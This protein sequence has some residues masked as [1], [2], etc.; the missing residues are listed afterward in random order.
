MKLRG[1]APLLA[2]ALLGSGAHMTGAHLTGAR[3]TIAHHATARSGSQSH[4]IQRSVRAETRGGPA[5][6]TPAATPFSIS[7]GSTSPVLREVGSQRWRTTVLLTDAYRAC[8]GKAYYWL[9]TTPPTS[10]QHKPPGI[11]GR[12][13]PAA[14]SV[15]GSSCQVT[16]TFTGL[17]GVPAAATLVLDQGGV[18]SSIPLTVSRQVTSF[19]SMGIPAIIGG[20]LALLMLVIATLRVRIYRRD[21]SRLRFYDPGFWKRPLHA[22]SAWSLNDSWATNITAAFAVIAAVLTAIPATESVFPG[23]ALDRFVIANLIAGGIVTISPLVFSIFYAHWTR[24]NLGVTPDATLTLPDGIMATLDGA[25]GEL[26]KGTRVALPP[27]A[28]PRPLAE[29]TPVVLPRG[30]PALLH[31]TGTFTLNGS[32][33]AIVPVGAQATL[34]VNTTVRPRRRW[35]VRRGDRTESPVL[36][37][38]PEG[39]R[40]MVPRTTV[41]Q[42]SAEGSAM[43]P[44]AEEVTL[45]ARTA[46]RLPGGTVGAVARTTKVTLY[47][48]T[49]TTLLPPVLRGRRGNAQ[50]TTRGAWSVTL[51]E[52]ATASLAAAGPERAA[53]PAGA[54]TIT[55]LPGSTATLDANARVPAR[56]APFGHGAAATIA[57]AAGGS[58][59]V[60]VDTTVTWKEGVAPKKRQVKAG[61][62]I[63]VPPGSDI[64]V[65]PGAAMALPGSTVAV[66]VQAGSMLRIDGRPG[67]LAIPED[68]LLPP[69]TRGRPR[70]R[71]QVQPSD[72]QDVRYPVCVAA[73]GGAQI[74]VTGTAD[75]GLPRNTWITAPHR[76]SSTLSW[77]RDLQLPQNSDVIAANL[78]IA[79]IAAVVTMFGIGAEIGVA[80]VL[81]WHFSA[82]SQGW[83]WAMLGA[84]LAVAAFVL[85]YAVTAISAIADPQPGSSMSSTSGASFTL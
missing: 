48:G 8:L 66:T 30:T 29:S 25:A 10:P 84:S 13:G 39:A 23:V 81:A 62:T 21:G 59:T 76:P 14:T 67:A 64:G 11:T 55:A 41:V 18:L 15:K 60:P 61:K 50:V 26:P 85:T 47:P 53:G 35:T 75:V 73:S 57:V 52:G 19:W 31:G 58:I 72:V 46:V 77:D 27:A 44:S 71:P 45:R 24:G 38:L 54:A 63:Q 33:A 37:R 36:V 28:E 4:P 7:P 69:K 68:A 22:A 56:L 9:E 65:L 16:L 74:S 32:S 80:A 2:A 82:A 78:R 40:I 43:L 3:I 12:A 6:A 34:L 70:W 42:L 17:P 49:A 20:V 79:V 83:R 5:A 51:P 1:A